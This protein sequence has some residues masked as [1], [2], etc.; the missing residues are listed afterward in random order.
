[1]GGRGA[2]SGISVKGKKYGTEY[3]TVLE[4]GNIKFVQQTEGG[5]AKAPME[6]MSK[7]RVY[8]TLGSKGEPNYITMY[9]KGKRIRQIDLNHPHDGMQPHTHRG[10]LHDENGTRPLSKAERKLV[11]RIR[12]IWQNKS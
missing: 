4:S 3:R 2:S 12:E 7:G 11:D 8:V 6:T 1:M 9:V 5:A 10:Y